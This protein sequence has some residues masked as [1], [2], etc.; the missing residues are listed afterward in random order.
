[1][2][3][4]PRAWEVADKTPAADTKETSCYHQRVFGLET[5]FYKLSGTCSKLNCRDGFMNLGFH[6][7]TKKF[8][9]FDFE[10]FSCKIILSSNRAVQIFSYLLSWLNLSIRLSEKKCLIKSASG[11][12]CVFE[13]MLFLRIVCLKTNNVILV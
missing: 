4:A 10:A 7:M 1:M 6:E 9:N 13:I 2:F 3:I 8:R 11:A 5:H 12:L